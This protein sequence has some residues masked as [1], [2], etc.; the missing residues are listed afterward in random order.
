MSSRFGIRSLYTKGCGNS[1]VG[2]PL[3]GDRTRSA[4]TFRRLI[5]SNCRGESL[6]ALTVPRATLL[7]GPATIPLSLRERA[8]VRAAGQGIYGAVHLNLPF[9]LRPWHCS[10]QGE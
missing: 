3:R 1:S 8:V 5:R 2:A 7:T 10:H 9:D 4:E 6:F